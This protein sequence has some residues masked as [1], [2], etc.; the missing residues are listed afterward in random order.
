MLEP[1][2]VASFT[3]VLKAIL[4]REFSCLLTFQMLSAILDP[5]YYN[6]LL[7]QFLVHLDQNDV[8]IS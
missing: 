5:S 4:L 7:R 6:E 8:P 1:R 3:K 2:L